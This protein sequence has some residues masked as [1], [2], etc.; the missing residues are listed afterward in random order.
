MLKE[1]ARFV[2]IGA[3]VAVLFAV[4]QSR[5]FRE[6]NGLMDGMV[7]GA[8][9][10][11]GF[12]TGM[13]FAREILLPADNLLGMQTESL[14][15]YGQVALVGLSDGV[16]GALIGIGF[17]AALDARQMVGRAITPFGGFAAAVAAHLAYDVIG[18]GNALGEG[19]VIRKW[20]ALLLPVL[21]VIVV[22]ILELGREKRAIADELRGETETGA[23]S[24]EELQALQSWLKRE[25]M[26]LGRLFRFDLGGWTTLHGLHNRQ[27]QLALTKRKAAR[28][29]DESRRQAAAG[30]VARLREAIFELK[31]TLGLA[32][33]PAVAGGEDAGG[34][35]AQ[36]GGG[37]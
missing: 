26:Y 27:V 30:E 4:G 15:G 25:A 6:I 2:A 12:A 31:R 7:Y 9:G 28:E 33:P 18:H 21:A 34:T 24:P 20:I 3:G 14:G 29:K 32:P 37:V 17:A 19:A 5:G 23:V 36:P 13:S 11:L 8:A 16:F 35:G 1:L 10:G 22:A